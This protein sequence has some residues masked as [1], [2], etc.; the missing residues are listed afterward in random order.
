MSGVPALRFPGFE[1]EWEEIKLGDVLRVKGRRNR[2]KT[3]GRE[4]VLS[5]SGDLG[6][7]NQIAH[8]GRSYAGADLGEYHVVEQG[9]V[10]YTKSPLKEN[11]FGIIKT[12]LGKPGIV[13]TLYAVYEVK[14]EHSPE[15]VNRYFEADDRTNAYLKPLVNK[16]AKNDMKIGN[17][18]VLID[19]VRFP[20]FAE[21]RKIAAFLSAVDARIALAGRER[22]G[23]G[24]FKAGLLQA[25]FS[26]ALRFARPDGGAFPEWEVSPLS[27][28]TTTFS[29]GTPTASN[30]TFYGGGI[31]FIKS[32]ELSAQVTEQTLT[33]KGLKKSS[34]K[35]VEKG[36]LLYALYGATSGETA[37]AR[38]SGAINQAVLCIRTSQNKDFLFQWLKMKKE[39]IRS[40]YL[41][42]GQGNLSAEIVKALQ[43]PLPHP[44]EQAR[45]ATALAALD[46]RA[47]IAAREEAA[48]ARF[49]AGLLQALFA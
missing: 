33:E 1:G 37:L 9:D 17:E 12:N 16:G 2:D 6:V 13:S 5:V 3:F 36:D 26:R 15:F 30:P 23:L 42:G 39:E 29:G 44:D 11:P 20:T 22:A 19:P 47:G 27:H 4:H 28:V 18:R 21:Q 32:G 14:D 35:L 25:L 38:T 7:V 48:L 41:Q 43:V 46:R 24:W 31:P 45:I 10:V 34:A 49:K 8:L 40:A